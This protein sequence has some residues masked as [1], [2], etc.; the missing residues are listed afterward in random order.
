MYHYRNELQRQAADNNASQLAAA[1]SWWKWDEGG[2]VGEE[3]Q[4]PEGVLRPR[5]KAMLRRYHKTFLDGQHD[6]RATS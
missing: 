3:P 5:W 6:E 4:A 2:R 1:S